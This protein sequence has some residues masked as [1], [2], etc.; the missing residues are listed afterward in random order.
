MQ[1]SDF[2]Q[3]TQFNKR[4]V[5]MAGSS[6]FKSIIRVCSSL[7]VILVFC[8]PLVSH[9]QVDKVSTYK[10][11]DGWKLQV[12][13]SDYYMKGVVW[14]YTP[15]G[16]NYS[17]NLFGQSD[18]Y[19]R[20]VL[21]YEFGLMADMGVNTIRSFTMIPPQWVTYIYREHGIMSII[22]PLMGRYG[23]DVGGKW[24]PFT[25]YSDPLTRETLK[26][27]MQDFVVRYKD[28]PGVLM[29]AFGNE[30]NYGLSWSSFEIENLPVGEQNTA[31]ARYLYSLWNEVTEAGKAIDPNHPF[32]IVNGDIQYIDLIAELI[33]N[34][35]LLGVNA[36]RGTSFTGLWRDVNE[37][38]DL[39]VVFF[40]FGSDAF[41]ARAFAE[42]QRSQALVLKDQWQEMYNKAAGNGEEGNSIGAFVFEWRD[43]WWKYLQIENLDIQD[44]NASW[45]NQAYLF[46]WAEGKNNMNEEWFGITGLGP[47][48]SDGVSTARPRMAYD[49][50]ADVFSMDPYTTSK[51]DINQTF[52][53]IDLGLYELRGDVRLL[54]AESQE[55]KRKL[56]FTG[57]R[58]Q[59]EMVVSG[60]ERGLDQDGENSLEFTDGQMVF[61]DFGFQPNDKVSGQLTVNILGNVAEKQPLEFTYGDRGLP[62]TFRAE[63][64]LNVETGVAGDSFGER[65]VTL[66]DR[67]RV[68]IYDFS[69]KYEGEIA[70][71]EAFYHTSR[72]HWGYEGDQ[73]GLIRE[74][75]DINGMDIWNA[76]APEGVEVTG[77]GKW[78]GLTLLF[79]PQVYWG[80][81]PKVVLKYDFNLAKFDWTFIHSE[82]LARRGSGDDPTDTTVRQ[83]RQT[84][85]TA[86]R[87]FGNG[88]KLELGGILS[89]PEEVDDVFDRVG[90]GNVY[91]DQIE[92]EDALGFKAKLTFP[93]FGTESYVQAHH[94]GL[95]ADGGA[96]HRTFGVTD[97]SRLPYSGMGNKQ[98]YEAGMIL[99]FGDLMLYPR[100]MYRDNLVHANPFIEPVS[101]GGLLSPGVNPR[102]TDN[103]PFAVLGNREARSAELYLTY[104]PTGATQFYDWDNDWREDAK[105]AFNVGG[106]YTNY[107]TQT[108]SYLFFFEPAASNVPFGQGLPA[109]DVWAA[110]TRM[111]F[112]PNAK[113]RYII[114]LIRGFDQSTG[115]PDGG[116]RDFY[117]LHWKAEFNRKHVFSGYYMK[118]SWGPF[119][120]YRQFNITFPE[121]IKLDYSVLLGG[122][123]AQFGSVDDENRATRLGIRTLYRSFDANNETFAT[124]GDYTFHT[125]LYFTYQF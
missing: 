39:P 108:D 21:D 103:D 83:S 102:D 46:D 121:Q 99:R 79:G 78:D 26:R 68:E 69:A 73:F 47:A 45:S 125:V 6:F 87:E 101:A 33:P 114:K 95:V 57:G 22:N 48:N 65:A 37:K 115:D 120:F 18:D 1:F 36:Y 88:M 20:K 41:N 100:V 53:N 27:D 77:K 2:H 11:A 118:D 35:D 52:A 113:S 30:S 43:E 32:T 92:A 74:T 71:V 96:V 85:L 80:A 25:D 49:V 17:Y 119:D 61:L 34:L 105:F 86:E 9:A 84:T 63:Q 15:R 19:I 40:E 106:T 111:V 5:A 12:N 62:L 93:L 3:E 60:D 107:P 90:D 117:Q 14:G 56:Q 110:S 70:D 55:S 76:K 66:S 31:K 13:G 72:F 98:E 8:W 59:G 54:K 23:Y 64:L 124:D 28:V 94:A 116:T 97:P 91:L 81:N 50:L 109:E 42:D 51:S 104:D 7:A 122:T 58:L 75:T 38:L 123:G 82:D 10:D 44:N 24:I 112:N 67:E 4:V 16:Q 89:A 29:F